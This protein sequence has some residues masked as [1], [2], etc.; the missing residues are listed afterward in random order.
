M[1]APARADGGGHDRAAPE[2]RNPDVPEFNTSD[3][4]R[5]RPRPRGLRLFS[6]FTRRERASFKVHKR[7]RSE[8]I[9]SR[10]LPELIDHLFQGFLDVFQYRGVL[11]SKL[12][13][14]VLSCQS[15][16]MDGLKLT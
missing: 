8:Q 6:S 9:R 3:L 2:L 5:S 11:I 7:A 4:T 15:P 14:R 16:V 13:H 10:A 12:N 1:K